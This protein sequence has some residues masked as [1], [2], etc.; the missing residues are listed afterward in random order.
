MKDYFAEQHATTRF[1]AENERHECI[2]GD[3]SDENPDS[4][5]FPVDGFPPMKSPRCRSTERQGTERKRNARF[6]LSGSP[7]FH[8]PLRAGNPIAMCTELLLIK[9]IV[10]Q[11]VEKPRREPTTQSMKLHLAV[12]TATR[13]GPR[14]GAEGASRSLFYGSWHG[15]LSRLTQSRFGGPADRRKTLILRKAEFQFH[16]WG[17]ATSQGERTP[18]RT[19]VL[20]KDRMI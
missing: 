10:E 20:C 19:P 16:G 7:L 17:L 4:V 18:S 2:R 14:G 9:G 8:K 3:V 15:H 6:A 11:L 12:W 5:N 1:R 13:K